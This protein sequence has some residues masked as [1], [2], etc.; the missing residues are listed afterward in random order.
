MLKP[1]HTVNNKTVPLTHSSGSILGWQPLIG[2]SLGVESEGDVC[3]RLRVMERERERE[4]ESVCVCVC[5]C[6]GVDGGG[7]ELSMVLKTRT[8]KEPIKGLVI[9][10]MVRPGSN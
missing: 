2:S 9:D 4:R 7:C 10:F 8:V 3:V 1:P 5:V 6:G